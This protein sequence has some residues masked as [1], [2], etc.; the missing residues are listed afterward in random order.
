MTR[1][2]LADG[3]VGEQLILDR[4]HYATMP[5][6]KALVCFV[7]DP[8]HRILNPVGLKA[9]LSGVHNGLRVEVFISPSTLPE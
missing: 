8:E 4:T 3:E 1:P 2:G 5:D 6:W 7:Y 9:D